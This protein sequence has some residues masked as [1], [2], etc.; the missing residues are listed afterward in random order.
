VSRPRPHLSPLLVGR[1]DLL[2]LVERRIGE[3]AGGRGLLLMLA[4]EAGIGKSRLLGAGLRKARASGFRIAKADLGPHDRQ[5][6]LASV[7]DL[8]R[9]MEDVGEFGTL[10]RDLLER[11]RDLGGDSLGA[12][13][14][15]VHDIADRIVAAVGAPT[16]LAFEDLQWADELSLEVVGE[17]ARRA[18]E[19]PLLLLATYRLDE[20]PAGSLQREWRSR[21]L[22]QRLAEEA[23]L[24]RLTYDQTAVMTTLILGTGL[25]APREVVGAVYTRTNGI[26]LHVEE[27]LAALDDDARVDGRA[28]RDA[29]VP[30]TIEDAVIAR[31]GR[32]SEDARSVARAGAVIGRCFIP[33]VLAGVLDRPLAE[34]DAPLEELVSAAILYPFDFLDHGF[35]DFRHQLLRDALYRSVPPPELRRF[36]ARAG[37]FGASMEG[38]S[39]IHASVHFERAGLHPQA[40][41]A[42]LAAARAASAISSR[43]EAFELYGRAVANAPDDL[44]PLERAQLYEAYAEAAYA[45][46]NVAVSE[47]TTRL[48]RRAYLDAGRPL[49]AAAQ[50]AAM[51]GIARR[52]VRPPDERRRPLE[53]AEAELMAQPDSAE[54][55]LLLADVYSLRAMFE[56]DA[57]RLEDAAANADE[58]DRQLKAAAAAGSADVDLDDPDAVRAEID[59]LSG[60]VER[61][62]RTM[63][64]VA[65]EARDANRE[66]AGVTSYRI[67]AA[68]AV[69]VMDYRTAEIGL[70]EGLRYADAI[71]QSYCRRIMSATAAHVAWAA[72]RW[73]EAVA[74]AEI[75]LVERGTR[76]GTLGSRDVL[77]FVAFGRGEVERA[78]ALFDASLD[79]ARTGG[80]PELVLPPLW[81]LAE[82]ALIADEPALAS[83]QCDEALALAETSGERALLVPFVVT[84]VRARLAE[85]RPDAAEEWSRRVNAHL[86]AWQ[87]HA[88][89]ALDHAE[90]LLRLAA[91][92]TGA[93]RAV[94]ERAIAGWDD[95]GRTWEA[96]W[97]RLDLAGCL[98]RMN[99]FAEAAALIREVRTTASRLD[100]R[101]LAER[102]DELARRAR[103]RGAEA[104]PWSPLTG[105]EFEVARLIAAGHTNR[106]IADELGIA[107]KTASAH[108]EHILAKLGA[109]RRAEIAAW[110][111]T[112]DAGALAGGAR[113]ARDGGALASAAVGGPSGR[114]AG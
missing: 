3:A 81:G 50:L 37:E 34:L 39:E 46:D 105:R 84:G 48:A 66:S 35:Y 74:T 58:A 79:V 53:Q 101:P 8:G 21:L 103:G 40:Y 24:E 44:A 7:L 31:V 52:D 56:I 41:R 113:Q 30:D 64:R 55:A 61:G 63:L 71:E 51:A 32:L 15:L 43:Q 1:D 110:V 94:L 75:E 65:R 91:G 78:R 107:A 5:V 93:A 68:L 76:R 108:V 57:L 106:A 9:T 96:S 13:R 14:M 38:A 87:G 80:E 23:R 109:T 97:G 22:S 72:G 19:R 92:S 86:K 42:A 36:H 111:A 99:R 98:M 2:Q 104:E 89:P 77:G 102:A 49:E 12:R 4:G 54:R 85:R 95:R 62:L 18:T 67:A 17:L 6:P 60:H 16:V 28:I 112:V 33:D 88:R 70:S 26:P 20:L 100:S 82:T 11:P 25:P 73:D 47:E 90:G 27:L 59:V 114:D 45:V 83:R 29:V 69:R 10:G